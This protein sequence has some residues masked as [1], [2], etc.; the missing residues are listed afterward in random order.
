MVVV[1]AQPAQKPEASPAELQWL[2]ASRRG[3]RGE[4]EES[5][6]VRARAWEK[7]R[8]RKEREEIVGR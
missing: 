5:A 3:E 1:E 6:S 8:E 4:G 2:F 7:E